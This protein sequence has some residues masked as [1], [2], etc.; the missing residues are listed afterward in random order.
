ML[1]AAYFRRYTK[2]LLGIGELDLEHSVTSEGGV[3]QPIFLRRRARHADVLPPSFSRVQMDL[4][5]RID[6]EVEHTLQIKFCI[7]E[8]RPKNRTQIAVWSS[9]ACISAGVN[10]LIPR[11]TCPC[12]LIHKV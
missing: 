5:M 2:D 8:E 3:R 9:F 1:G 12:C 11:D 7:Q 10:Y 4:M 6:G